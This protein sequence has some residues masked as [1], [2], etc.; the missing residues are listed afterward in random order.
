MKERIIETRDNKKLAAYLWEPAEGDKYVLVICHGF[1]G[2]KENGGKVFAFADKLKKVG[3]GVVAFDF[4]G[5]G[6]SE[7]DFAAVTLSRQ[8]EDLQAVIDHVHQA[9]GLPV[10]LLGRSMGGSSVLAGAS[11][12]ERVAGY[13]FWSTPVFTSR[14]P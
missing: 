9:Y 1:R 11:G 4:R 6:N 12:D 10:I 3:V 13:T 7:G 5:C 14:S 2:A 8:G